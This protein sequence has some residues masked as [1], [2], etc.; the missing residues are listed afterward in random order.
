LRSFYKKNDGGGE[1]K[2][3][4]KS[5]ENDGG[6]FETLRDEKALPALIL[7]FV[8]F[9]TVFTVAMYADGYG[10]LGDFSRFFRG[11]DRS[12]Y[13]TTSAR[14]SGREPVGGAGER[15]RTEVPGV[16]KQDLA[17]AREKIK[18]QEAEKARRKEKEPIGD[19]IGGQVNEEDDPCDK[20]DGGK[21][22]YC[23]QRKYLDCNDF[24]GADTACDND[25]DDDGWP[26]MCPGGI[27]GAG[28]VE[29]VDGG[30]KKD[31]TNGDRISGEDV[32]VCSNCDVHEQQKAYLADNDYDQDGWPDTCEG[33]DALCVPDRRSY[34]DPSNGGRYNTDYQEGEGE[35]ESISSFW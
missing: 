31:M 23:Q 1:L 27:I 35:R 8:V 16:D 15:D 30:E 14:D 25:V 19:R 21:K 20:F 10:P 9:L 22:I 17:E 4:K 24:M 2:I 12:R 11:D 32:P 26:D 3:M 18:E 5:K 6:F 29:D 13:D 33:Y 34:G 28:C 7:F